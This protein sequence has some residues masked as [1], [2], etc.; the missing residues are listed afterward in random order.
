MYIRSNLLAVYL[1]TSYYISRSSIVSANYRTVRVSKINLL[2]LYL[3]NYFV[4]LLCQLGI[5]NSKISQLFKL[6]VI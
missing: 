1:D 5:L 6:A 4:V 3:R 2:E